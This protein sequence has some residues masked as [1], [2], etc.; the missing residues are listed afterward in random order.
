MYNRFETGVHPRDEIKDIL[1]AAKDHS[2]SLED[3]VRLLEKVWANIGGILHE[4]SFNI[5][6]Y[7]TNSGNV[8]LSEPFASLID[9]S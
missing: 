6:F 5:N 7:E 9:I 8:I 1:S 3:H 4:S 2:A